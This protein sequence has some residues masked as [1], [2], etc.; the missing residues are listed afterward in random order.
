MQNYIQKI[1]IFF[2]VAGLVFTFSCINENEIEQRS[3]EEE[4]SELDSM[5]NKLIVKGYDLDTT[6]LGVYYIVKEEGEGPFPVK[7]DT[8]FIEY[9]TF[10]LNGQLIESSFDLHTN[11]KS[12]FLL[13]VSGIPSMTPGWENGI[14]RMNAGSKI[15]FYVPSNLAY[16]KDG[17]KSIPPYSTL[18]YR[19]IMHDL[20]PVDE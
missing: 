15:D 16:G 19:T 18:I 7:G 5:L 4:L 6:N 3:F 14:K 20:G 12:I 13:G 10:L 11:G 8:C 9:K 2:I 1:G 17:T